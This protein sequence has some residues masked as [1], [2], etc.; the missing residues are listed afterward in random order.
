MRL[1]RRGQ[2]VHGDFQLVWSGAPGEHVAERLVHRLGNL[3]H[4]LHHARSLQQQPENGGLGIKLM[5]EHHA[6]ADCA[7]GDLPADEKHRYATRSCGPHSCGR[8]EGA[9]AGDRQA[10][11][12]PSCNGGIT[13]SHVGRR[14]LVSHTH[15]AHVRVVVPGVVEGGHL[16]AHQPEDG[17]HGVALERAE[18]G[19]AAGDSRH[20]APLEMKLAEG[21]EEQAQTGRRPPSKHVNAKW[22]RRTNT[23]A[24]LLHDFGATNSLTGDF[25]LSLHSVSSFGRVTGY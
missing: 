7:G 19:L 8:V 21:M 25:R 16:L 12:R 9:G 4:A 15:L 22:E 5:R 14:L 20:A 23:G 10:H 11:A 1:A 3:L 18:Q 24:R 6:L 2:H 13:H 17:V